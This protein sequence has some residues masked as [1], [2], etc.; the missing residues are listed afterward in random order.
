MDC[1]GGQSTTV[2]VDKGGDEEL[3]GVGGVMKKK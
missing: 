1:S 2:K 3:A